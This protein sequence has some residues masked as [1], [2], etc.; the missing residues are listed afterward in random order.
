MDR[1]AVKRIVARAGALGGEAV[2]F[3]VHALFESMADDGVTAQDVFHVLAHVEEV[4]P[5]DD[6]GTIWKAYGPLVSGDE[7]AVVTLM[8]DRGRVRVLTTHDPP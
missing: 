8:L 2:E 4:V 3:T 6:E 7:Y 1:R 5:Q